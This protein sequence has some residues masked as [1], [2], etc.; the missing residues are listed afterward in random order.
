M[1]NLRG[2]WDSKCA[3]SF[4]IVRLHLLINVCIYYQNITYSVVFFSFW[5]KRVVDKSG[6][7]VLKVMLAL[8]INTDTEYVKEITIRLKSVCDLYIAILTVI[9]AVT[10]RSR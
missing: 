1:I 5:P 10:V 7:C 4:I 8:T 3:K 9:C 2:V 6:T